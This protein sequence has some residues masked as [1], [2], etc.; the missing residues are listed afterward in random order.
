MR[1]ED[2]GGRDTLNTFF[3]IRYPLTAVAD[4]VNTVYFF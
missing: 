1:K 4:T 3:T 2:I